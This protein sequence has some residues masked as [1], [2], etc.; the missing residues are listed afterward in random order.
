MAGDDS[1]PVST[2]FNVHCRL[3]RLHRKRCGQRREEEQP[4]Q[5]AWSSEGTPLCLCMYFHGLFSSMHCL[6]F[7]RRLAPL[8]ALALRCGASA[9]LLQEM[10]GKDARNLQI[11][12]TAA[13]PA[14][15]S[16]GQEGAEDEQLRREDTKEGWPP[17]NTDLELRA[18]LPPGELHPL[19]K[20]LASG[21]IWSICVRLRFPG[22]AA[23][24]AERV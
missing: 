8:W 4:S 5:P 7:I 21:S 23:E 22:L 19:C 3:N 10:L 15:R 17:M 6:L 18:P 2:A 20:C 9:T 24:A 13:A 1:G 12:T 16:R 14:R 11:S